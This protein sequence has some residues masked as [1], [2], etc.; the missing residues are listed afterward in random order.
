M[1]DRKKI[2]YF[3]KKN[4]LPSIWKED[5]QN[6]GER[7][8]TAALFYKVTSTMH[9]RKTRLQGKG[10]RLLPIEEYMETSIQKGILGEMQSPR[11]DIYMERKARFYDFLIRGTNSKEI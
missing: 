11:M 3:S 2:F 7:K 8:V 9:I 5:H 6:F 4:G 10:K 1:K